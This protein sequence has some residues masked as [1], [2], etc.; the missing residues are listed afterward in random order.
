MTMTLRESLD[1]VAA[2]LPEDRLRE[3]LDFAHF[4]AIRTEQLEWQSFGQARLAAA[5]GAHEPEYSLADLKT[6]TCH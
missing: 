4:L 5:Y 2:R 1:Y 6:T 3:L